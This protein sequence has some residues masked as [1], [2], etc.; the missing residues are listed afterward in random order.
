[1]HLDSHLNSEAKQSM[2]EADYYTK[3]L[4]NSNQ[5]VKPLG[6]RVLRAVL[7]VKPRQGTWFLNPRVNSIYLLVNYDNYGKSP[8]L[9]GKSTING[10]FQ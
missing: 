6:K 9:M 1:M 7:S 10:H 3:T 2:M 5:N 8:G 4:Q